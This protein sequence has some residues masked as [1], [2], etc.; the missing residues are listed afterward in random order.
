MSLLETVLRSARPLLQLLIVAASTASL[1]ACRSTAVT[2]TAP[3]EINKCSI[4]LA[5]PQTAISPSGGNLQVVLTTTAECAW[6]ASA[7][8]SWLARIEPSSGQGSGNLQIDV[9]PNPASVAR[10]SAIVVNGVRAQIQQLPAP[11]VYAVS[12]SGS[13]SLAGTGGT[14]QLT[15]STPI[16][17]T[18]TASSPV[19]WVRITSGSPGSGSG[20]VTLAVEPNPSDA[21]VAEVA[22]ANQ[23]FSVFQAAS[24]APRLVGP[25]NAPTP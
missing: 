6:T 21:R 11:C 16:G 24:G 23:S 3:T 4:T 12:G 5:A 10:Q 8:A 2:S 19:T 17:C 14:F 22:I 7:E 20:V 18:W 1:C 9:G 13:H 25:A 15:V